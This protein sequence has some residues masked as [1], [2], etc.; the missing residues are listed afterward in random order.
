MS[1]ERTFVAFILSNFLGK[2][3]INSDLWKAIG[4]AHFHRSKEFSPPS[5]NR[6]GKHRPYGNGKAKLVKKRKH[7]ST[8]EKK[9][10][11]LIYAER[12]VCK[13]RERKN[14]RKFLD[15][16]F[17]NDGY[18]FKYKL[19]CFHHPRLSLHNCFLW[20]VWRYLHV[21]RL[22]ADA[23]SYTHKKSVFRFISI[24]SFNKQSW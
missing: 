13:L 16:Y 20:N 3:N 14:L 9:K 5:L 21:G 19:L 22:R 8:A 4:R 23:C 6:S 15:V 18:S 1:L 7:G 10:K 24:L 17:W 2:V 11:F 12:F